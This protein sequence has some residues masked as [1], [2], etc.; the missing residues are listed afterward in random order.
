MAIILLYDLC[1]C[2]DQ[3]LDTPSKWTWD[4]I[5]DDDDTVSRPR[6]L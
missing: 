4:I 2:R 5:Y 6:S 3:I 1:L